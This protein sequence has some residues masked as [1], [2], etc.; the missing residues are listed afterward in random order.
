MLTIEERIAQELCVSPNQINAAVKLMD[1]GATVPFIARY[2]KEATQG[3]DD[4]QLRS[5]QERL[6]YLRELEERRETILNIIQTQNKLNPELKAQI[7]QAQTKI[8][9]EDL[10]RPYKPKRRTKGQIAIEAGLKPLSEALWQDP[11]LNP[12]TIAEQYINHE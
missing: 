11:T 7:L 8:Q 4:I 2:R 9:L 12:A 5:L 3:L 6:L 1:E 10:Y